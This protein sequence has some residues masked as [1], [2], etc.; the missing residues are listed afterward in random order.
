MRLKNKKTLYFNVHSCT[1]AEES[2]KRMYDNELKAGED[3]EFARKGTVFTVSAGDGYFIV[4]CNKFTIHFEDYNQMV[5][6]GW[7][8]IVESGDNNA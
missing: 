8:D 5:E 3:Y 2:P 6:S 1:V 4:Y 7:F